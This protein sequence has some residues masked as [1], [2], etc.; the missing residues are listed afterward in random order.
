VR[1]REAALEEQAHRVAL[2]AEARLHADEHIAELRADD[3][4]LRPSVSCLPGTG[5]HWASI[6][7]RCGSRA[8][9]SSAGIRCGRWPCAPYC[10]ALPSMI[11]LRRASTSSGHV[12]VVALFAQARSVLYRDWNTDRLAAVPV[13]P[14]CGGK[15]E[16]HD[17]QA[18]R[19]RG[20]RRS[21]QFF[22]AV[23]EDIDALRVGAHGVLALAARR[24]GLIAAPAEH[25]RLVAPSSSGMATIIVASTGIRPF[26]VLPLLDALELQGVGGDVGH[27]QLAR[28][29][30]LPP[31]R[32]CR[33]GRRPGKTRSGTGAVD[34]RLAV[35]VDEV[36]LDR[37]ARVEAA[38]ERGDHAQAALTQRGDQPV[39]MGVLPARA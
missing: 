5:P 30:L 26:R 21:D 7:A 19:S 14:A 15:V 10:A 22:D 9:W 39:V 12:D 31:R 20:V 27:V 23:G 33:P 6:S 1:G 2:V 28:A 11:A 36:L 35:L 16:D 8:T 3:E 4:Q 38:G 32:R 17:R 24:R 18:T 37:R 29:W 25:G 13:L 34:D